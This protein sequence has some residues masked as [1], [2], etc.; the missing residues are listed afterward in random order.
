MKKAIAIAAAACLW[1]SIVL[2]GPFI[3]ADPNPEEDDVRW[4][5]V[6]LQDGSIIRTDYGI[7]HESGAMIVMDM[8]EHQAS[9]PSGQEV[10]LTIKA[11]NLAGESPPSDPLSFIMPAGAPGLPQIGGFEP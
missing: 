3:V 2:A 8:A 5:I 7:Q 9:F 6:T 11:V 10:S 4:Y 1:S